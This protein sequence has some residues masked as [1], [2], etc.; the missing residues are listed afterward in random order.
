MK[1]LIDEKIILN[2]QRKKQIHNDH[3]S[4]SFFLWKA[5]IGSKRALPH[6]DGRNTES[7]VV[8]FLAKARV[9]GKEG[10]KRNYYFY[11]YYYN[12]TSIFP[13]RSKQCLKIAI[14]ECENNV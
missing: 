7:S 14:G 4:T 8:T 6:K 5:K 10:G 9:I 3:V 1:L 2:N 11:Y 12:F 13:M